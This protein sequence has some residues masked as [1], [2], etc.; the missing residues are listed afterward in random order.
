MAD[1]YIKNKHGIPHSIPADV[2]A[3]ALA[4]GAV[5]ITKAEYTKLLKKVMDEAAAAKAADKGDGNEESAA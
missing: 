2:L 1:K 3:T 4:Q 5:E